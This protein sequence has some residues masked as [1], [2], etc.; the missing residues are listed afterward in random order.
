MLAQV[1]IGEAPIAVSRGKVG[2]E[3]DGVVVFS[4]C[5]LQASLLLKVHSG[6]VALGL[7]PALCRR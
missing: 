4:Y 1:V 6:V 2:V 5:P 7:V 3:A